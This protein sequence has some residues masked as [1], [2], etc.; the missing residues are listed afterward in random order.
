MSLKWPAL[1]SGLAYTSF[2]LEVTTYWASV[3]YLSLVTEISWG[4]RD[5]YTAQSL[6]L[7]QTRRIWPLYDLGKVSSCLPSFAGQVLWLLIVPSLEKQLSSP[8]REISRRGDNYSAPAMPLWC[9]KM[10]FFPTSVCS[11]KCLFLCLGCQAFSWLNEK[12]RLPGVSLGTAWN[13]NC[14]LESSACV[15]SCTKHVGILWVYI[16]HV[17]EKY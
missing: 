15:S 4:R 17:F 3:T 14:L 1:G 13:L 7:S 16:S 6:T 8:R 2:S 5:Y 10:G 9:L 11:S 12:Q